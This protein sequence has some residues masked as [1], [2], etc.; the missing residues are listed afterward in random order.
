MRTDTSQLSNPPM[1]FLIV[2]SAI[3]DQEPSN[4][5]VLRVKHFRVKLSFL[6]PTSKKAQVFAFRDTKS[7]L[8]RIP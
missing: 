3:K 7:G 4:P 2:R 1:L 5:N 6:L 8:W